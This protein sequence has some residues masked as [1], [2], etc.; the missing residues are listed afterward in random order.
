M[1]K[2]RRHMA[3]ADPRLIRRCLAWD[4]ELPADSRTV[5]KFCSSA[6]R[7]RH[8][9]AMNPA[10]E[11]P[12]WTGVR[13]HWHLGGSSFLA[14]DYHVGY[15]RGPDGCPPE[16][17]GIK[18]PNTSSQAI[19]KG[20][21][22][23]SPHWTAASSSYGS[24]LDARAHRPGARRC[25]APTC[26]AE[27]V[28]STR[29]RRGPSPCGTGLRVPCRAMSHSGVMWYRPPFSVPSLPTAQKVPSGA[30]ATALICVSARYLVG[31]SPL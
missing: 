9:D 1:H 17:I 30:A 5:R 6:C 28:R 4:R 7:R 15:W 26:P 20:R 10:P 22:G 2:R 13:L 21:E 27:P 12:G 18:P 11:E 24:P 29:V 23:V 8:W 31:M 25:A 19:P 14:G 3:S 16:C